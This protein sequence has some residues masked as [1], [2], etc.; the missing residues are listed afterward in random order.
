MNSGAYF[1]FY[2]NSRA[3]ANAYLVD[4]KMKDFKLRGGNPMEVQNNLLEQMGCGMAFQLKIAKPIKYSFEIDG[5]AYEIKL[6]GGEHGYLWLSGQEPSVVDAAGRI[7][8]SR[9]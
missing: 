7:Q 5:S 3:M 2:K 4:Y 9:S 8:D 1:D 6:Q